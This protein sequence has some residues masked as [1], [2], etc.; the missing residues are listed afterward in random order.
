MAL[1]IGWL[2]GPEQYRHTRFLI[3]KIIVLRRRNKALRRLLAE[4]ER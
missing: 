2:H 3:A 1:L 4:S